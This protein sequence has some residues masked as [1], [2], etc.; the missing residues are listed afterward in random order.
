[1][2][3]EAKIDLLLI[4]FGGFIFFFV[5]VILINVRRT[6]YPKVLTRFTNKLQIWESNGE[7]DLILE[8]I[9]RFIKRFP[10]ETSFQWSKARALYKI[11]KY[12]NA[13]LIFAQLAESEPLW[14]EDVAKYISTIDDRSSQ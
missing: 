13:R 2:D 4:M 9:D 1:M 5:C 14:K 11:G 8:N 12:E 10:G 6:L 3:I 7:H